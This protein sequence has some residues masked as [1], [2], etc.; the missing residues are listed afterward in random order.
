[1]HL[2]YR[3]FSQS[4]GDVTLSDRTLELGAKL[5]IFL[6]KG[7]NCFL[8]G[9][10]PFIS[11]GLGICLQFEHSM[12]LCLCAL[13]KVYLEVS[14]FFIIGSDACGSV[15]TQICHLLG[16]ALFVTPLQSMALQVE[17]SLLVSVEVALLLEKTLDGDLGVV[18]CNMLIERLRVSSTKLRGEF[19]LLLGVWR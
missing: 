5:W 15:L 17:I 9:S 8:Q 2:F 16:S 11:L 6:S 1:M 19:V 18:H 7:L 10:Y 4:D 3:E 14:E 12:L 13:E